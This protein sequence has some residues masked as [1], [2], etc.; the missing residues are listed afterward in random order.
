MSK[1]EFEESFAEIGRRI[2]AFIGGIGEAFRRL[3]NRIATGGLFERFERTASG[4]NTKEKLAERVA[5]AKEK[6]EDS[7]AGTSMVLG[8]FGA[9]AALVAVVV[10]VLVFG[11]GLFRGTGV[12]E[13]D[14]E[15]DARLRQAADRAQAEREGALNPAA[16]MQRQQQDAAARAEGESAQRPPARGGVTPSKQASGGG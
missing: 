15:R 13:A 9:G 8:A 4:P 7:Q 6:L 3:R 5:D 1:R 16:M 14:L 2:D 12:T 10:L 11:F